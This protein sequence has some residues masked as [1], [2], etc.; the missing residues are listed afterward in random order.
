MTSPEYQQVIENYYK[1]VV[2]INFNRLK[3]GIEGTLADGLNAPMPFEVHVEATNT[4]NAICSYGD[5]LLQKDSATKKSPWFLA[6]HF[7]NN[8]LKH[9]KR[10]AGMIQKNGGFFFCNGGCHPGIFVEEPYRTEATSDGLIS[11]SFFESLVP[12]VNWVLVG[13]IQPE[14]HLNDRQKAWFEGQKAAY[15]E[16]F[17]GKSVIGTLKKVLED[18]SIA[19]N[20]EA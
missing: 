15:R 5:V 7:A 3:K 20:D 14:E 16:H 9:D 19:I 10:T 17:E 2:V 13:D 1:K 12:D 6:C 11:V 4:L 8:R 18:L